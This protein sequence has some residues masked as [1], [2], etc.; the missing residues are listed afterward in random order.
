MTLYYQ[1]KVTGAY[2]L[3][4]LSCGIDYMSM[5]I[6]NDVMIYREI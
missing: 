1:F 6:E 3:Y 2:S 4:L 5:F